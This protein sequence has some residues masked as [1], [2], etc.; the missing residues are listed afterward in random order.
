MIQ[1]DGRDQSLEKKEK[2]HANPLSGLIGL[3]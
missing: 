2:F 1:H 3:N